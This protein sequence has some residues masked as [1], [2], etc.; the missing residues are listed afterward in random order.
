MACPF[1]IFSLLFL[2]ALRGGQYTGFRKATSLSASDLVRFQVRIE[3]G[4]QDED[5][6][7]R[8]ASFFQA[9]KDRDTL[10]LYGDFDNLE[11]F[12]ARIIK[13]RQ[14]EKSAMDSRHH[15]WARIKEE[16]SR[17]IVQNP[18]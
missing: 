6:R 8:V 11:H 4:L 14:K 5:T 3:D 13:A 12:Y 9:L 1:L 17:E 15:D 10:P 18:S 2:V 7:E 16:L